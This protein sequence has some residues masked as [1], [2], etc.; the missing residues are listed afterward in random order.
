MTYKFRSRTSQGIFEIWIDERS[1]QYYERH[2]GTGPAD[3]W[4]AFQSISRSEAEMYLACYDYEEGWRM[5]N[6]MI[7]FLASAVIGSALGALLYWIVD[8][9]P[10][11]EWDEE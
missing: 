1:G 2:R 3:I 9:D 7:G 5:E 4:T 8:Q 10:G 6:I 11:G